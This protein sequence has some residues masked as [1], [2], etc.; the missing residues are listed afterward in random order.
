[1]HNP[2]AAALTYY[3]LLTTTLEKLLGKRRTKKLLKK[4]RK[5]LPVKDELGRCRFPKEQR[6]LCE[7][8]FFFLFSTWR[9]EQ[10]QVS[11]GYFADRPPSA[12]AGGY[13][14]SNFVIARQL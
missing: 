4:Q 2:A 12:N 11:S 8:C 3:L 6:F 14:A 7:Q 1:M 9:H 13:P 5:A 10:K